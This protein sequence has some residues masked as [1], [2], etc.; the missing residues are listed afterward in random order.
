LTLSGSTKIAIRGIHLQY[1]S[2]KNVDRSYIGSL[3]VEPTAGGSIR[4]AFLSDLRMRL[5]LPVAKLQAEID[6][7][8]NGLPATAATED[9]QVQAEPPML[10]RGETVGY[11]SFVLLN[12]LIFF[13]ICNIAYSN[14]RFLRTYLK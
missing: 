12:V 1:N 14:F 10:L 3:H 4:E 6:C 7:H 8:A 2:S 13:Q 9:N 11:I 5:D